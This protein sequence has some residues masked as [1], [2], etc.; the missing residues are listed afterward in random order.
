[1]SDTLVVA[2]PE[3]IVGGATFSNIYNS[4]EEL[5]RNTPEAT[6]LFAFRNA[7]TA[8]D[9]SPYY[10]N[11]EAII[12]Q[13]ISTPEFRAEFPRSSY[14]ILT[15][16]GR[17]GLGRKD[18]DYSPKRIVS[19]VKESC[20]LMGSDYLDAV[21][22]HDVEYVAEDQ[23]GFTKGGHCTV[24]S[25]LDH[26]T[27]PPLDPA[28]KVEEYGQSYGPG[29]ETIIL[30]VKTLFQ[31]KKEG[32][33]RCVGISGYPLGTLLRISHLIRA[34]LGSPLDLVMSYSCLTLQ[35]KTL[36]SYTPYL[37]ATGVAQII[38]ASPLG[39]GILTSRGPSDWH[40]APEPLRHTIKEISTTVH[41][42]YHIPIERL[43]LH[44]SL[45]FS[46]TVVGFSS[47]DEVKAALDV[48]Q[49]IR[50]PTKVDPAVALAITD[51]KDTLH[52][53]G[54]LDWAWPVL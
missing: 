28:P 13:I 23:G 50:N 31:L 32:L 7:L 27:A 51:V 49:D 9:T 40:P 34:Q 45:S 8:I 1:M 52:K 29:D 46:P 21:Y 14:Q 53:A 33:I 47:V 36:E 44:H 15:K 17:Y 54:L 10:G 20:R 41:R 22:L 37:K 38:S 25:S 5:K 39:N 11:S 3:I 48:S 12:G 18:F 24:P 26:H 30:A 42:K 35:N 6:L 4:D 19:S 43:A 16:C 2:L